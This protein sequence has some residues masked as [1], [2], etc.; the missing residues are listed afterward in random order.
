MRGEALRAVAAAGGAAVVR[1]AG[2][3]AWADVR[4]RTAGLFGGGAE[5][6]Q[7]LDAL[8]RTRAELAAGGGAADAGAQWRDRFARRLDGLD[9]AERLRFIG[10]LAELAAAEAGPAAAGA[11]G[12]A[13]VQGDL[14]VRAERGAV[15]GVFQGSVHLENPRPP[16]ADQG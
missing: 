10:G 7:V 2:T 16:G 3:D 9:G 1:A 14:S 5:R 15:A 6:Q 4:E 8:D 12:G 13:T 11:G